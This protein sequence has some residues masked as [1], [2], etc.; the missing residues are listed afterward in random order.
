MIQDFRLK[1]FQTVALRLSFT[2]AA[3]ELFISQP[4]VTRHINEL[5]KNIGRPLFN[6]HGNNISLTTEGALMLVF[7]NKIIAGYEQLDQE[8]NR[9]Q[10]TV[11]GQLHIGASTTVAQYVLPKILAQFRMAYPQI[12]LSLVND[13]TSNIETLVLERKIDIG[14]IEGNARNPLLHYD[15]FVKDEIVLATRTANTIVKGAEIS[16]AKVPSLPLVVREAGSGTQD[17]IDQALQDAGIHRNELK[18]ELA[19][20][21]PESLKNYLLHSNAFA[22]LSI[23]AILEEMRQHKLRIIEVKE[24]TITRHFHFVSLHGQHSQIAGRFKSACLM[25]YNRGQ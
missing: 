25:H 16:L 24:L 4:A 3:R 17:V 7:A 20:G 10:E 6:R 12:Q 15:P 2:Q 8:L 1:V 5:E 23:H 13:N 19:L 14:V 9:L 21:G 11:S 22:F 18:I